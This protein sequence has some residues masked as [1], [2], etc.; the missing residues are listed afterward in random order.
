MVPWDTFRVNVDPIFQTPTQN[1]SPHGFFGS[2]KG[3]KTP[4][5][6]RFDGGFSFYWTSLGPPVVY[7]KSP[8]DRVFLEFDIFTGNDDSNKRQTFCGCAGLLPSFLMEITGGVVM[9]HESGAPA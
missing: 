4:P 5:G 1:I 9:L 6:G 7:K 2:P 8:R 3:H